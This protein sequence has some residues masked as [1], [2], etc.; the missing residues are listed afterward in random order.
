[1]SIIRSEKFFGR[2]RKT[3]LTA[4]Q[5]V[6]AGGIFRTNIR[7]RQKMHRRTKLPNRLHNRASAQVISES[8]RATHDRFR[9]RTPSYNQKRDSGTKSVILHKDALSPDRSTNKPPA[10]KTVVQN[11]SCRRTQ[12]LSTSNLNKFITPFVR[13]QS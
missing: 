6:G 9:C 2:L 10:A 4:H 12:S 3:A 11:T 7:S 5:R 13:I 8:G 1:M